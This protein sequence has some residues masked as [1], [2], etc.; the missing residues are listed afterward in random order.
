MANAKYKPLSFSTTMRNP[1]RICDFLKCLL[2][3]EGLI[4]DNNLILKVIKEIIKRKLY[5]PTIIGAN[6]ELKNIYENEETFF[7]E[8]QL[9][10]IVNSSV[11]QHK[12]AGFDAGWPSRFDTLYKLSMEFGYI[13]YAIGE[14]VI[15]TK[16]GH[17]M[18]E[19]VSGSEVNEEL[20]QNLF[21]NTLVKY[22]V[23]NPYRK[24]KN[25]NVPLVFLLNILKELKRINPQSAGLMRQELSLLIC[26]PDSDV[27][28]IISLI[29][30][31]RARYG[32]RGYSDEVI[33][34]ECLR[35]LG[36]SRAQSK[37]YKMDKILNESVDEYIRK[38]RSTGVISLRG[39]GRF[40]DFNSLELKKITYILENYP[41]HITINNTE[42]YI[43]YIG[44]VD[45]VLIEA[46]AVS[47]IKQNDAIKL[48]AL[49][50]FALK[51]DKDYIINELRT[52]CATSGKK[53][54]SNDPILKY[55]D[56]PTRLEFLTS[57]S[58]LQ[59]FSD[60]EVIPNY[61][62][63]DEGIPINHA[64]GGKADIVCIDKLFEGLVE[65]TLMLGRKQTHEEILPIARHLT[66][67]L[68]L[69]ENVVAVFI[70]P[71]IFADAKRMAGYL[72]VSENLN[73]IPLDIEEFINIEGM[74]DTFD[75]AI[76]SIIC[77]A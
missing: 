42:E 65:V 25:D 53:K 52:L 4:L 55:I 31:L 61:I 35:V 49:R 14:P 60:L 41:K 40:I 30:D 54:A 29:L 71:L 39:N 2:P 6:L 21:L 48:N 28:N 67:E 77:A 3:F 33:Y 56:G 63:D 18:I 47:L 1:R 16:T 46:K 74:Y 20:V 72:K 15:I 34:E 36:A 44:S 26:W 76:T 66:E 57:I 73:I 70:A 64:A 45:D 22:P 13:R 75:N 27:D 38:M 10:F 17:L 32:M 37:Y 43:E 51:Y 5:R 62:V 8:A 11:Q 68:T 24:I 19:A 23:N 7:N 50:R 9:D 12:E 69:R 59:S 58:L